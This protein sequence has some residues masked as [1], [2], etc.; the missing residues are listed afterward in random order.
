[1]KLQESILAPVFGLN[2][3]YG[4][5]QSEILTFQK[6]REAQRLFNVRLFCIS[7]FSLRCPRDLVAE[8][9]LPWEEKI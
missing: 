9:H 6:T 3:L 5:N 7:F 2:Y 8:T 4:N 1:M